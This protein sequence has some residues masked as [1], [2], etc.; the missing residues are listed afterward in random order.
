[1]VVSK[2]IMNDLIIKIK[3][4]VDTVVDNNDMY[5]GCYLVVDVVNLKLKKETDIKISDKVVI[6]LDLSNDIGYSIRDNIGY[7][8][9]ELKNSYVSAILDRLIHI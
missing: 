8:K 4:L 5:S 9:D 3:A 7:N 2:K 6:G 1:M